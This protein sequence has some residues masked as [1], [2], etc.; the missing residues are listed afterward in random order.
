MPTTKRNIG[1]EIVE[2]LVALKRGRIARITYR[3]SMSKHVGRGTV[4]AD[5][6]LPDADRMLVK[7]GLAAAVGR[8][9]SDRKLSPAEAAEILGL[10]QPKLSNLLRG[11]LRAFSERRLMECLTLLGHDVQI[12][13][14]STSDP[15]GMGKLSVVVM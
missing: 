1:R 13:V 2:G 6:R 10:T 15:R 9:I 11:H 7:A 5:L 14:K 3:P 8:I 4:Y 12:A